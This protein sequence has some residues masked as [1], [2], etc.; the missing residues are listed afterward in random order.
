MLKEQIQHTINQFDYSSIQ[1]ERK[2]DLVP[3]IEYINQKLEDKQPIQLNFICTHNSRRSQMAQIWAKVAAHTNGIEVSTFSGGMEITA[4]HP[5]AV[6]AMI[7]LGFEIEADSQEKEN[8]NYMLRF[9]SSTKEMKLFSKKYDDPFNPQQKFAAIMTC[10]HADETCPFVLGMDKRI[11][12]PYEDPKA[13]DG[14]ENCISKYKERSLQ[15]ATE[16]FYVFNQIK[17]PEK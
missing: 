9:S 17:N 15:I 7:A 2:K 6:K 1:E 12:L 11:S 13:F 14:Q 10:S 8:P 16:L 4:F 5:N 3:L